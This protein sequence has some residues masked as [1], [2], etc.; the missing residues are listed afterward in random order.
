[1]TRFVSQP[2]SKSNRDQ[3][4]FSQKVIFSTAGDGIMSQAD[5]KSKNSFAKISLFSS[6]HPLPLGKVPV[7]PHQ[8][9]AAPLVL[10]RLLNRL[11]TG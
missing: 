8:L 6:L 11:P 2:G 10:F 1:M 5:N 3:M 4:A 7:N 9:D